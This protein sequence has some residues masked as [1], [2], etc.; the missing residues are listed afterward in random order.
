MRLGDSMRQSG[1]LLGAEDF[2]LAAIAR[3]PRDI[4]A[5]LRLGETQLASG[6]TDRAE[7]SFRSALALRPGNADASVGLAVALLSRGDPQAALA[8]ITPVA[9]SS[10]NPRVLRNYGVTLDMLGRPEEAQAAY[11]RG[12]AQTPADPDLRGN[13][14]LSLAISGDMA[15]AQREIRA[16]V[17]SPNAPER[18]SLN[19]VVLLAMAGQEAEAREAGRQVAQPGRIEALITQGHR[20]GAAQGPTARAVAL[21]TITAQ[22]TP[23]LPQQAPGP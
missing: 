4:S 1:D 2:Y 16:A 18:E 23:G 12:L 10:R 7:Q 21:G 17:N 15:G 19:Q 20:A 8:Y 6:A 3:D 9:L 5:L 22:A 11:R 13:L 14:A